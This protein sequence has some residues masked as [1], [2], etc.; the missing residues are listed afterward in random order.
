MRLIARLD[1]KNEHVIKG[2]HLEGLRKVGDPNDLARLY[3]DQGIDEIVFMDAVASLYDRNNLFNIIEQACRNVFVPIAVGGGLRTVDDVSKALGA[4]ADK[5]VINTGAM[6]NIHFIEEV[7]R[8]FGSQCLVGSI[9][10]KRR[11]GGWKAYIDN[12]R[13]PTNHDVIAWAHAL[14]D[15]GCG[16][17]LLTSVD[18]EGTGRGFDLDLVEQV[19]AAISRPLIVSGGYGKPEQLDALLARTEPSAV[20][21]ASVLHYKRATVDELRQAAHFRRG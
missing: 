4:G 13:E 14:Q 1:I 2:I 9:E 17:I 15:A 21:F 19:N 8:K 10:A 7:A 20:A 12:G 3:Y 18:Q 11:D 5:V 16:E 6:R